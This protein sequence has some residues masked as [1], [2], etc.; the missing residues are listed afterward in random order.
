M[1]RGKSF[2]AV[3]K[4]RNFEEDFDP[5]IFVEEAQKIYIDSHEALAGYL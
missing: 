2:R 1:R 5:R 4:L 3:R